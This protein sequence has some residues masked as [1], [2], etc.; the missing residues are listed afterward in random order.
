MGG[1]G[2]EGQTGSRISSVFYFC[3][4]WAG[5]S[6]ELGLNASLSHYKDKYIIERGNEMET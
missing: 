4:I 3:Q 1:T 5:I 2:R 6:G